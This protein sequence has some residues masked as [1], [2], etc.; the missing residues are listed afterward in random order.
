[1]ADKETENDDQPQEEKKKSSISIVQII[2]IV[3]LVAVLGLGGFIAWK[4]I[5]LEIPVAQNEQQLAT[6]DIPEAGP[7]ILIDMENITINLADEDESRFLRVK[8]KLEVE[9]EESKLKVDTYTVQIK[10]LIITILSSKRFDDVRTPQG[11]YD[12]KE[13]LV[14]R[15]NSLLS[16][17]VVKNMYFSDFVAQ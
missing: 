4:L 17:E 11:K 15:I 13:E 12:L 5:N 2:I 8:M 3:L 7:G 14:Y 16:G 10:D 6:E 1:M 9:N